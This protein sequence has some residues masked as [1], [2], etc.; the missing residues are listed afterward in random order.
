MLKRGR[1]SAWSWAGGFLKVLRMHI[2]TAHNDLNATCLACSLL[3]F[4]ESS[5]ESLR[6]K[7]RRIDCILE[8][9]KNKNYYLLTV[10]L[11]KMNFNE[12]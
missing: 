10:P 9:N 6:H 7:N 3:L 4:Y 1:A 11:H 8:K 12:Y 2:S 5:S